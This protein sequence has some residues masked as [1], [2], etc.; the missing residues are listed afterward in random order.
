MIGKNNNGKDIY[1]KSGR[2]GPYLQYEQ[3]EEE[4]ENKKKTKKRKKSEGDNFKNVSI[5]KGIEINN[6]IGRAHV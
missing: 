3:I 4:I 1:L 6:K 5:P 2:F